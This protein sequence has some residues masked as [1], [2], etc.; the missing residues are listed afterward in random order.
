MK[1]NME[2]REISTFVDEKKNHGVKVKLTEYRG[3]NQRGKTVQKLRKLR[4]CKTEAGPAFLV[5]GTSRPRT[6][7]GSPRHTA[8][9]RPGHSVPVLPAPSL[10]PVWSVLAD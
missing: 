9:P 3:A 8:G 4:T 6:V 5:L 10:R 2:Y 1:L 7:R